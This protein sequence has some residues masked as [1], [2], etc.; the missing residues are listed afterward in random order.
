[1]QLPAHRSIG[2][3]QECQLMRVHKTTHSGA[4][5]ECGFNQGGPFGIRSF[6]VPGV[7]SYMLATP[8]AELR[9][10]DV[11]WQFLMI[12]KSCLGGLGV[13]LILTLSEM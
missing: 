3:E 4:K 11:C 5:K 13:S 10:P 12:C 7:P 6:P 1:M 2:G 8:T 9:L